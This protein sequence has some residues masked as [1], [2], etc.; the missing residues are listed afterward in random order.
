MQLCGDFMLHV[1]MK[2]SQ[3]DKPRGTPRR[4]VRPRWKHSCCANKSVFLTCRDLSQPRYWWMI[5]VNSCEVKTI[6]SGSVQL[7]AIVYCL[8]SCLG[9]REGPVVAMVANT[10]YSSVAHHTEA[11]K[12]IYWDDTMWS[13]MSEQHSH[14]SANTLLRKSGAIHV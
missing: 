3:L 1:C 5:G 6:S 10:R 8:I 11:H 7:H 12:T 9:M 13:N 2:P 14:N 4:P